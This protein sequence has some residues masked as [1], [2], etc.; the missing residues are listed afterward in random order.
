MNSRRILTAALIVAALG[1]SGCWRMTIKSGLPTGT[2]PIEYDGKWHSGVIVGIAELSGPYLLDKTCPQGWSEIH[3]ETSFPNG[4][5]QA[6]TSNIYTPQS[7]TVRCAA[8]S[9]H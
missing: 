2:T 4:L 8:P 6:L 3:T 9:G 5:V 1:V 7:V